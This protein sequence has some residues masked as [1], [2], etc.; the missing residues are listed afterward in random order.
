MGYYDD[1]KNVEQYI[2]MAAGY[3]GA[4]LIAVLRHHLPAEASV[5]ELGMGPGTDL[6]LLGEHFTVTGSDASVV[7]V[8]RFRQQYP[9]ADVLHLDAVTMQTER[10]F[11][12]LYSNKVLYHLTRAQLRQS[13]AQQR[14]VLRPGGLAL[15]SFWHGVGDEAQQGLHFAYYD[16]SELRALAEPHYEVLTIE[17]Y[18]EMETDDSLYILLRKPALDA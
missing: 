17:R 2:Q 13:L 11:D 18:T 4:D 12:A 15:H 14:R 16:A 9:Q 8:E 5:L 7:F 6:L 1:E 3:D 10:Q